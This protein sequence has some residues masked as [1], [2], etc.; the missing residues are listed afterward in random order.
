MRKMLKKITMLTV[1][2]SMAAMLIIP[3]AAMDFSV[4]SVLPEN[5]RGNGSVFFDL[6]VHPGQEQDLVIEISN[7]KDTEIV[8]LVETITASTSRNG[9]IN[10]TSK[11]E[12]DESLKYS[13]EDMVNLPESHYKIPAKSTIQVPISLTIPDEPFEGAILGSIR[14]L[15]EATQ[16]EK[17]AGGAVVNQYAYATAVRLVQ[18]EDAEAI[19]AD[20]ILGDITAELINYRASIIAQIRNPQPK[21]IKGAK[22]TAV[23]YPRGSDQA[24]FEYNLAELDFA[25]NSVFNYSFV[26]REGYG[27]DAGEYTAKIGIEYDGRNWDFEQDFTIEPQVAAAMNDGALN[28]QGQVRKDAETANVSGIP[29]WGIIAAAAGVAIFAALV[30]LTITVA[31]K[32]PA[33]A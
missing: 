33:S 12:L 15:R 7:I 13:F 2:V 6:I 28:Q 20:F 29:M 24:I 11:G 26:D 4:M 22:A 27:I 25:P 16:E 23:I 21:V 18:S 14:V 10:Y 9:E 3:A 32:R 19:E 31:R 30:A 1:V 8:V 5:Q 17:D